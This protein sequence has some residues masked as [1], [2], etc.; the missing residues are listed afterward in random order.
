[1]VS[2]VYCAIT[3][4][5]KLNTLYAFILL[6]ICVLMQSAVNVF[7]DYFDYVKGTDSED[8]SSDDAFDAVLVYNN[9]NPEAPW[10]SPS[11]ILPLL[12]S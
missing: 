12:A 5:G 7:N 10:L 2:Y 4:S 8:N 9:I 11:L 1:M 3:Y 6:L